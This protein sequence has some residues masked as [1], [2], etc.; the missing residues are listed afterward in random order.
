MDDRITDRPPGPEPW[1]DVPP[2]E[3]PGAFRL[4]AEPHRGVLLLVAGIAVLV[5]ELVGFF[6]LS[7]LSSP[8]TDVALIG[9]GVVVVVPVTLA[10]GLTVR[11][12]ARRDLERMRRGMVDPR[13]EP[14]TADARRSGAAAAGVA[15]L[16]GVTWALH[17]LRTLIFGW[18]S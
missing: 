15:V 18:A 2:W 9:S 13:G 10:L 11:A 12:L 6:G 14:L 17:L 8:R 4:D 3:R 5:L 1:G 7:V 16:I